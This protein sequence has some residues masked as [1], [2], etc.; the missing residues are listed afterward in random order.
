MKISK[1]DEKRKFENEYLMTKNIGNHAFLDWG[2]ELGGVGP[3]TIDHTQISSYV[4]KRDLLW[5]FPEFW[6]LFCSAVPIQPLSGQ[7]ARKCTAGLSIGNPSNIKRLSHKASKTPHGNCSPP[8]PNTTR[9]E[10]VK[11]YYSGH[12]G[13]TKFTFLLFFFSLRVI[14]YSFVEDYSF[15]ILAI[16][17]Q[18]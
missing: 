1:C 10:K 17:K 9:E 3:K 14:Y 6:N 18:V 7:I 4:H 12:Q 5:P 8:N 11:M 2:G 16:Q 13:R 15:I